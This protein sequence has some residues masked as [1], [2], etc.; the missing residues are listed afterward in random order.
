MWDTIKDYLNS[1]I[2]AAF[3]FATF[4]IIPEIRAKRKY[5][6][7][8]FIGAVVLAYLGIDKINRDNRARNGYESSIG[9]LNEKLSDLERAKSSDSLHRIT[10][11]IKNAEFQ[12]DL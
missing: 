8:F 6:I 7:P 10:D 11:S 5:W 4:F 12:T 2:G 3:L 1:F 9:T